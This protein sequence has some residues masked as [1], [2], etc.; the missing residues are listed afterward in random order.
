[1]EYELKIKPS[2]IQALCL[3]VFSFSLVAVP[4]ELQKE[5]DKR[6]AQNL[7]SEILCDFDFEN[8]SFEQLKPTWIPIKGEYKV[9]NGKLEGR[10]LPDDK[11]VSTSGM[12]LKIGNKA[13]VY[14]EVE[15]H[16]AKNVIVTLNGKGKGRGH[17]CRVVI[18]QNFLRVQSDSKPKAVNETRKQKHKASQT[19]KILIELNHDT[20]SARVLNGKNSEPL[21]IKQEYINWPI[22]NIR[23]AVSKGPARI[24]QLCVAKLKEKQN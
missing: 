16:K 22:D 13:L 14:F 20:L 2:F 12:D 4:P 1:M 5:L 7:T 11:H 24:D 18:T 3:F 19:Y 17:I 6:K 15:L 23:W 21:T 8:T 9:V 10:E